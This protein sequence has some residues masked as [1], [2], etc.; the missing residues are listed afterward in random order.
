MARRDDGR[1]RLVG[2]AICLVE[3]NA[4][5]TFSYRDDATGET[6]PVAETPRH[7][8]YLIAPGLTPPDLAAKPHECLLKE[9]ADVVRLQASSPSTL[10]LFPDL[11]D[12]TRVEP[13]GGQLPLAD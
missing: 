3:T 11:C 7:T 5:V 12:G 4:L 9:G 8:R 13:F 10:H 2:I 1:L 6:I